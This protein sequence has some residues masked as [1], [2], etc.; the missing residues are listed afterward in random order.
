MAHTRTLRL[1]AVHQ[2]AVDTGPVQPC[3]YDQKIYYKLVG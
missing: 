2:V 1:K 3:F